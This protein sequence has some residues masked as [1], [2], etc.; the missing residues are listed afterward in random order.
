MKKY[1]LLLFLIAPSL[2]FSITGE[3]IMEKVREKDH[4]QSIHSAVLLEIIA[5]DGSVQERKIESRMMEDKKGNT[6]SLME[7]KSPASVKNT[8][9]LIK[10]PEEGKDDKWIFLPALGKVRRIT[11]SEGQ[12]TFMGTEFTY[13]DLSSQDAEDRNYT[14]LK[15][16]EYGK[17]L[18]W[19]VESIPKEPENNQYSKAIIWIIQ[20]EDIL[21]PAKTELYNREDK[22]I[23][24]LTMEKYA[25]YQGFWLPGIIK[26]DNLEN[27]RSSLLHNLKTAVNKK[28]NPRFFT[29]RY[30]E[31][32]RVAK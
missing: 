9:F 16:E 12:N 26:M 28:L 18:C 30:L 5:S 20:N 32:G 22:L 7:F 10:T 8:R 11:A 14:L 17:Y 13:D 21:S 3:E 23:K 24:V 4:P 1:C 31:T 15:E 6:Y 29:K 19:V 25:N 2:L 27:G